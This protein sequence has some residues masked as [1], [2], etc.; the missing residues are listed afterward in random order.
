VFMYSGSG[1]LRNYAKRNNSENSH[2]AKKNILSS[3]EMKANEPSLMQ[4][5]N[6]VHSVQPQDGLHPKR[7]Q[8]AS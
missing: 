4:R 2:K 1:S 3:T 7:E 6:S 8:R 5:M